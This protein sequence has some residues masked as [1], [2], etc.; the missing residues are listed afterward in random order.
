M[1]EL[2]KKYEKPL[3]SSHRNAPSEHVVNVDNSFLQ[4]IKEVF[5]LNCQ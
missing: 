2:K 4:K 3:P 1:E 5:V